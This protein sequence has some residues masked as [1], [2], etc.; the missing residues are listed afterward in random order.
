MLAAHDD[1][2]LE[3]LASKGLVRR[4]RRDADGGKFR[5]IRRGDQDAEVCA[6]GETVVVPM[7]GAK[8]ASCGC[9]AVG[10][11]RHIL[12]A[13]M[14]LRTE[15][16]T[17]PSTT[18]VREELLTIDEA[19]LR[20]FAGADLSRA[21]ALAQ[22]SESAL[23]E[24]EGGTLCV[25]LPDAPTPVIF[26]A[27]QG[28][29]GVVFKGPKTR[30][31]L[32]VSAA[33]IVVRAQA[34]LIQPEPEAGDAAAP[35]LTQEFLSEVQDA[36]AVS[37]MAVLNGNA[38]LAR[39]RLFD[40]SVA[41]RAQAA[42]RLT[43]LLR[44]LSRQ[45]G[46]TQ[47]RDIA[48]DETDFLTDAAYSTALACALMQAPGDA[49]LTGVITRTYRDAPPMD[50]VILG[51]GVWRT[52][53]G[54]R[55]LRVYAYDL[56]GQ[57]WHVTGPARAASADPTFMPR[58]AYDLPLWAAAS[59]RTATGAHIHLAAPRIA[60]DG[61][62]PTSLTGSLSRSECALSDLIAAKACYRNWNAALADLDQQLGTGLHRGG[63]PKPVML[64]PTALL[65]PTFD[66]LNQIYELE[67][68]DANGASLSLTFAADNAMRV[69]WLAK[70]WRKGDA[71]LCD[72][73]P[74][75]HG[76]RLA[77][78]SL[79]R[80]ID[81][82]GITNLSLDR[83]P[84]EGQ[85]MLGRLLGKF[86]PSPAKGA[87][88]IEDPLSKALKTTVDAAISCL[89]YGKSEDLRSAGATLGSAGMLTLERACNALSES[90]SANDALRLAYLIAEARR[91]CDRPE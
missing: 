80:S 11:C 68:R 67:V 54:A 76:V 33:T 49:A 29:K 43:S 90:R 3:A 71:I 20:A 35:S 74:E 85:S 57:R 13:I 42:P 61:T 40:L 37:L 75:H 23:I 21:L 58:A 60:D 34:G 51:A 1:T 26:L 25:T 38:I 69:Q 14:A 50:I 55:G 2:A 22:A 64:Q 72:A 31:R 17:E 4:A 82:E 41:A 44:A 12:L 27:G 15:T 89:V 47:S 24:A 86:Q 52:P 48:F 6:D 10:I 46:L 9:T 53:G 91:L 45:A 87:G 70:A 77:P 16:G 36:I 81:R 56:V 30:V 59:I 19:E 28:M 5:I 8:A 65:K 79:L 7:A 83:M 18:D 66:D 32:V 62:L 84:G 39:D 63:T 73:L 78:L 88:I